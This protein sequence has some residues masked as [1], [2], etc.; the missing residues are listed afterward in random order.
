MLHCLTPMLAILALTVL[1][2]A[3][4]VP[5]SGQ[6]T[7]ETTLLGRDINGNPVP[8]DDPRAEFAYD[9]VLDATW[10]LT[11]NSTRQGLTW[12]EARR[13]AAELIV[14]PHSGW[15]LP[16]AD[17]TCGFGNGYGFD[18]TSSELG[19]LYYTALG[20]PAEGPLENT[21]PFKNLLPG[22]YWSGTQLVTNVEGAWT[23]D[24]S[25]GGQSTHYIYLR[26][27]GLYA[28]AV[29]P[30]DLVI[31]EPATEAMLLAGLAIGGIAMR[32]TSRRRKP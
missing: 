3:H 20:N 16:V 30:G 14:G 31:P 2:E 11:G 9:T 19:E 5:V 22:V 13:W 29:R 27:F 15:T 17:P 4:A 28:L 24:M 12:D 7:W 18:C 23:F 25:S 32:R 21:G 8:I 6:G 10:Y 26:P 1:G